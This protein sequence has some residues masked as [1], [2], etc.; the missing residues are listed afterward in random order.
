[1]IEIS[2]ITKLYK[3]RELRESD[4]D[5]ILELCRKNPLFY[6]HTEAEATRERILEDMKATP[7]GIG[8]EDKYFFG[9]L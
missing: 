2:K 4:V 1:M 7:P 5:A 3:T 8:L 9:F 6:E